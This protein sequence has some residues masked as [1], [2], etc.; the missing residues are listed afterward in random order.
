M[1]FTEI[2]SD[3]FRI[4][5]NPADSVVNFLANMGS[6]RN[7]TTLSIRLTKTNLYAIIAFYAH[8]KDFLVALKLVLVLNQ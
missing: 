4:L 6:D 1:I 8:G 2:D 7:I 3:D 5:D